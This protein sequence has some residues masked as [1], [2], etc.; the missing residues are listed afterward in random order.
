M[1]QHFKY[2]KKDYDHVNYFIKKIYFQYIKKKSW[3]HVKFF[4]SSELST[5]PCLHLDAIFVI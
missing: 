1:G 5:L 4:T 3:L 2:K